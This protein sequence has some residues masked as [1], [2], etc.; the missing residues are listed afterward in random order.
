MRHL[1]HLARPEEKTTGL[2]S[3]LAG[4]GPR[5]TIIVGTKHI[6]CCVSMMA[7]S[8]KLYIK[9]LHRKAGA[10][11]RNGTRR[12]RFHPLATGPAR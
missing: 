4:G 8:R 12:R 10:L 5:P 9:K 2:S 1:G 11:S 3:G 6:G 7:S